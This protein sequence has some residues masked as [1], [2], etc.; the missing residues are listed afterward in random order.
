MFFHTKKHLHKQNKTKQNK[1]KQNKGKRNEDLK[2]QKPM[3]DNVG[4]L[5][6]TDCGDNTGMKRPN[7]RVKDDDYLD[8]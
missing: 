8:V 7:Q 4:L 1:A 2:C 5:P 3:N 6:D